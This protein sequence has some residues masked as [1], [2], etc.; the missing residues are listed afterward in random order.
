MTGSPRPALRV[1]QIGNAS[2]GPGGVSSV[3]RTTSTWADDDLVVREWPSYWHGSR[4]RTV[5]ALARTTAKALFS[6]VGPTDVWHFH[7]TQEGSFL[8]EGLLLWIGRRR[9]VCCTALVHGSHFVA[10]AEANR[11]LAGRV[12]RR[13]AVVFVLTEPASEMVRSLGV[14]A[15]RVANAVPIADEPVTA[16]RS[17][18]VFA[19][20]IGERKGADVLLEAWAAAGV[21]GHELVLLGDLARRFRLPDP[22]PDGVVVQGPVGPDEVLARLRTAVALVLPSRAEAMPMIILESMSL[23]TPVIATDVGQI[24][25]VVDSTG[26]VVPP[27]DAAA[28]G[29]AIRRL[30]DSPELARRLGQSAWDRVRTRHSND[31][32]KGTF[33]AHWAACVSAAR[34]GDKPLPD[35]PDS[36]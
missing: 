17:G 18:F 3:V 25:E 33:V 29:T 24:A 23:G 26:L 28:L 22:L 9:G 31:V 32:V 36:T 11:R 10:F 35:P 21:E 16:G 30:A 34:P 2:G 19:G 12:L 7:L 1:T 27:A 5:A 14:P 15:V 6:K 4:R 20:E 8:R 13:P